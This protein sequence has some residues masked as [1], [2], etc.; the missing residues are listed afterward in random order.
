MQNPDTQAMKDGAYIKQ[1]EH[2]NGVLKERLAATEKDAARYRWLRSCV[3]DD[4]RMSMLA[5]S[6]PAT[7]EE[8]DE[9][10]DEA[11]I[12]SRKP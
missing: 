4:H 10:V 11:M 1:L 5:H 9:V 2:E 6:E 12:A 3:N 7:P 8:F